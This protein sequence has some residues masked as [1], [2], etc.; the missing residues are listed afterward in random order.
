M[1]GDDDEL[2]DIKELESPAVVEPFDVYDL[3][4][5]KVLHQVTSVD[6]LPDGIYIVNGKKIL[7]KK[8]LYVINLLK[9]AGLT[10]MWVQSA[11]LPRGGI[12]ANFIIKREVIFSHDKY[13]GTPIVVIQRDFS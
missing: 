6:G 5:H 2:T 1:N 11:L 3:S 7:K 8:Q 4:G 12:E 13:N 10:G 9:Q